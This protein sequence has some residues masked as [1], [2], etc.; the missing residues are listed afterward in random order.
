MEHIGLTVIAEDAEE[1]PLLKFVDDLQRLKDLPSGVIDVAHRSASAMEVRIRFPLSVFD[2]SVGQFMATLFGEFPF[3]RAFGR[4]RFENLTL[5]AEVFE[6]FR[7]PAFGAS[8]VLERFG[9]QESPLLVAIIKPSLDPDLTIDGL[10]ARVA[11]PVSGGFHAAKDDEMQGDFPNLTLKDRLD[12]AARNRGYIPAVNLDDTTAFRNVLQRQEIG[13]VMVNG[14]ILGFPTLYELRK[15]TR[16]PILSHLSMQGVYSGAFS[17]RVFALLH[18][19]FGADAL[20]TP[21]GD[22]HY[23]RASKADEQEIAFTLTSDLPIAKTLPMFTGGGRMD[24]LGELMEPYEAAGVPYGIVLGG[25]IFNSAKPPREMAEEVV[26]TIAAAKRNFAA[27]KV[28][29]VL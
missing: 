18:R 12:L 24:N 15:A 22:T 3:M 11:G 6:W 13:M 27:A 14:T 9:A 17:H 5:P 21:I 29:K 8:E 23:Y 4:A 16:V 20:I 25:L 7:G 10:A 28:T 1:G 19:L 26:R 2:R